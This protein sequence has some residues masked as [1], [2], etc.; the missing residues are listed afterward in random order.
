[1]LFV[2]VNFLGRFFLSVILFSLV[3]HYL[4]KKIPSA[5]IA[6]VLV[7]GDI[8]HSPR[9]QYHAHCLSKI[10]KCKV[11]LIGF[12]GSQPISEIAQDPR[13]SFRYL[14]K[15]RSSFNSMPFAVY[16]ILKVSWEMIQV[17]MILFLSEKG[18]IILAQT[19]PALPTLF[20]CWIVGKIRGIPVVFDFHNLGFSILS[21]CHSEPEISANLIVRYYYKLEKMFASCCDGALCVSESMKKFLVNNWGV[22]NIKVLYDRPG[23]QFIGKCER[24]DY[25]NYDFVL[26]SSTSWTDDED[27]DILLR[28]ISIYDTKIENIYRK[29]IIPAGVI[30]K[31]LLLITGK[32]P[33]KEKF[34]RNF[35]EIS[36]KFITLE[37]AWLKAEDYPKILGSADVGISMHSSSSGLDLPMKVVDM[38]GA[39]L[40]VV[41][42]NY[43]AISEL[44]DSSKGVLF[45]N[46]EQLAQA[47]FDLTYSANSDKK[48]SAMS[49][50]AKH[51]RNETFQ[52]QWQKVFSNIKL[53]TLI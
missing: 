48:R 4:S 44:V 3:F 24:Q 7:L 13:I 35:Q 20:I 40:P 53:Q 32:G 42:H 23:P 12:S 1:M 34:I 30:P 8:G 10:W 51:W 14:S 38:F 5:N 11:V 17:F 41:A 47:L 27:F 43:S 36:P 49:K 39:E 2:L 22:Q 31:V 26:V 9:M 25:K 15:F 50:A 45:D 6:Y 33:N 29:G 16:A 18:K 37:T 19:P 46:H 21:G 28:A 52:T